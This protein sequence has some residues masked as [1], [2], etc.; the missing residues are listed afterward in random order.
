MSVRPVGGAQPGP[1]AVARPRLPSTEAILPYL[2]SIDEARWYSNFG[3]MLMAF[4]AR[5]AARFTAGAADFL[6]QYPIKRSDGGF[7]ASSTVRFE[8]CFS[9]FWR[10]ATSFSCSDLREPISSSMSLSCVSNFLT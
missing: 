10:M 4:E 7:A 6:S 3:P 2:R 9:N 5:L 1:I 8:T